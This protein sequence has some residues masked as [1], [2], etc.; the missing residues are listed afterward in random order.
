MAAANRSHTC[1]N[2]TAAQWLYL[3]RQAVNDLAAEIVHSG[4]IS[5]R[6]W[7][8][9]HQL[10]EQQQELL[11]QLEVLRLRQSRARDSRDETQRHAVYSAAGKASCM[12]E[13]LQTQ[14]RMRGRDA[15]L[16]SDKD[17]KEMRPQKHA[18]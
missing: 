17:N 3:H 11:A 9:G 5:R 18:A 12:S 4:L 16:P 15:S 14:E 8:F 1:F 6:R 7:Q 13:K 10:D 2:V